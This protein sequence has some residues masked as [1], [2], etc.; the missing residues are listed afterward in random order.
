MPSHCTREL[1][2]A[3][4]TPMFQ[5]G[6]TG[7]FIG[8]E[9]FDHPGGIQSSGYE[10]PDGFRCRWSDAAVFQY[11]SE[12]DFEHGKIARPVGTGSLTVDGANPRYFITHEAHNSFDGMSLHWV[13]R[14]TG[15]R[16]GTV[17]ATCTTVNGSR[18]G[19]EDVIWWC[20]HLHSAAPG[21][22]PVA[23]RC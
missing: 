3:D 16:T 12:V 21:P 6:D 2:V 5:P 10:C 23:P 9:V 7:N 11:A 1:F 19:F 18:L 15:L 13:G 4:N 8:V 14:T 22:V 20:Q 17:T